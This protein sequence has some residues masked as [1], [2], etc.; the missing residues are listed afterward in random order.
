[1]QDASF[2]GL[3]LA[4]LGSLERD[5]EAALAGAGDERAV[6]AVRVAAL[7]KKGSVSGLMKNLGSMSP[8]ERK[9]AG[10][11]LNGLKDRIAAAIEARRGA[12]REAELDA[13]LAHETL[14]V[15]LPARPEA[16]GTVHPIT[17][18]WQ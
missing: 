8:E 2:T 7:G 17:Q 13:R 5:I 14:D 15:T 3:T 11:A 9:T 16:A 18:V 12:L 1:M 6:E 4:D 10:P